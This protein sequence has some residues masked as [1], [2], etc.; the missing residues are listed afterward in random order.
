MRSISGNVIK[1][2]VRLTLAKRDRLAGVLTSH[3][4]KPLIGVENR[5]YSKMMVPPSTLERTV[6]CRGDQ[7]K[8]TGERFAREKRRS[9][10]GR[11]GRILN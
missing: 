8:C 3:E 9:R 4:G 2:V 11:V 7:V 6:I 5:A 10:R 1:E